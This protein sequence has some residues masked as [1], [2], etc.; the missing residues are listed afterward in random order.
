MRK[1]QD[2]QTAIAY[3]LKRNTLFRRHKPMPSEIFRYA[4]H[5]NLDKHKTN[6]HEVFLL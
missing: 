6:R 2:K 1:T 4:R 3:K 5:K